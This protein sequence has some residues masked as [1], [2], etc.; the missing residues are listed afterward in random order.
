VRLR[1]VQL[2]FDTGFER[3]LT[4]TASDSINA[5]IVREP[6]PETMK[7]YRRVGRA[8]DG[9][10]VELAGEAFN[11]QRLRRH[12]FEPVELSAVRLV[13]RET[14]GAPEARLYEMRAYG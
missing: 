5:R 2:T 7:S 4:L 8:P 3:E 10:E 14:H 9:G 13:C 1:R 6:Q 11:Y 12:D